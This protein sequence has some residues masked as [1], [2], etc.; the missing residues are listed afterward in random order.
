M[1]LLETVLAGAV[2]GLL[3]LPASAALIATG[4][5]TD[6]QVSPGEYQYNLTLHNTGTTTIGTFWFSWV[7]G[8]NFMSATPTSITSPTGWTENVTTGPGSAIEWT[9]GSSLLAAGSSLTGFSFQSTET[10][11]QLAGFA[12]P[13]YQT[14]PVTTTFVYIGAPLTDPGYQFV[15]PVPSAVPLPGALGLL[16][17]G[18]SLTSLVGWR[19]RSR[20]SELPA[21]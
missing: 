11:A 17:G 10:P 18:L 3:A 5:L 1:K 9:A 8:L 16:V 14:F 6:T 21:M 4:T 12:A 7:P 15:V 20:R 19:S 13:P 2:C